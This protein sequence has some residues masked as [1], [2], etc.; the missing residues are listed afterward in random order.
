M[1]GVFASLYKYGDVLMDRL[2]PQDPDNVRLA[3]CLLR[4]VFVS[5]CF[6]FVFLVAFSL[7]LLQLACCL[8]VV[9]ALALCLLPQCCCSSCSL[10]VFLHLIL[11]FAGCLLWAP[12]SVDPFPPL[13]A[14]S[15]VGYIC[16]WELVLDLGSPNLH[17]RDP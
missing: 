3:L 1:P 13:W 7:L 10:F 8:N 14:A 6:L 15:P 11:M 16:T 9:S 5:Y 4:S 2:L 12:S 17:G